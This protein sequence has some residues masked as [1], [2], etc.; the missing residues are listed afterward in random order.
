MRSSR[1]LRKALGLLMIAVLAGL[2]VPPEGVSETSFS[3]E[4]FRSVTL[5]G[6]G[7]VIV[8]HGPAQR[9]TLLKGRRECTSV[10]VE[11]GELFIEGPHRRCRGERGLTILV[12]TPE[13][14][15]VMVTNGGT[16]RT[17]GA[18]PAQREL[19]GTVENGGRLDI[20]SMK[21]D[22][23]R[24]A[25][26]QGGGILTR[27][28]ASLIAKVEQGGAVS[29]WGNPKVKSSVHHGGAVVRGRP[30]DADRPLEEIGAAARMPV[31]PLPPLP[32]NGR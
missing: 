20:R 23:V 18:F 25:V 17:S 2:A 3:V 8:R 9:V 24:A 22:V 14:D 31:P 26:R 7:E 29:Y 1:I 6:G 16:L 27:P 11:E 4:S 32:P 12:Q 15:Q 10:T 30:G 28:Q 19:V 5:M 13:I 21:A